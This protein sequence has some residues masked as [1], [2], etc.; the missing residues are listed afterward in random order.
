MPEAPSPKSQKLV[1]EPTLGY[2]KIRGLVSGLRYQ[3]IYSNV[4]YELVEYEQGDA[5]DYC[6][7]VWF[8]KKFEL[9]LEFPNLPYFIHDG[10]MLT[11]TLAIHHYIADVWDKELLGVTAQER[12]R[13]LM[14]WGVIGDLK[15]QTTTPCYTSGDKDKILKAID[16]KLPAIV[17][18][19]SDQFLIGPKP[20]I[21]DFFFF[22][23]LQTIIFY[24]DE[25]VFKDHPVLEG[26]NKRVKELK[27]LKEYFAKPD[28]YDSTLPFNNKC[29]KINGKM[30]L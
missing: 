20:T 4:K 5:P 11:E 18:Q 10:L 30:P 24:S 2:W 23:L 19:M 28:C 25:K 8:D 12:A 7:K 22:E 1:D 16:D 29:A 6:S 27:G 26:Y 9:G 3:L 13:V 21:V 15:S 17:K 14:F